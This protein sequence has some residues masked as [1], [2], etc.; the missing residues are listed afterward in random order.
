MKEKKKQT[1]SKI[2]ESDWYCHL[3]NKYILLK[4]LSLSHRQKNLALNLNYLFCVC[5]CFFFFEI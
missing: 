3:K 2:H 4:V 1:M 5:V